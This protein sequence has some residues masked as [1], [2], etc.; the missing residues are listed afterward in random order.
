MSAVGSERRRDLSSTIKRL[1]SDGYLQG[2]EVLLQKARE[3]P[4]IILAVP[5]DPLTKNR[6]AKN[7][8]HIPG[9]RQPSQTAMPIAKH[10]SDKTPEQQPENIQLSD[11]LPA[12]P[13]GHI[14]SPSPLERDGE[15]SLAQVT[16]PSPLEVYPDPSSEKA[17]MRPSP[18]YCRIGKAYPA[19]SENKPAWINTT[20]FESHYHEPQETI[21]ENPNTIIN[22]ITPQVSVAA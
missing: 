4:E 16:P 20:D 11:T 13:A 12:S 21:S 15:R 19:P 17:G 8:P 1:E 9:R 22:P 5:N 6:T 10:S 14:T 18:Q 3:N 2:Y 7:K